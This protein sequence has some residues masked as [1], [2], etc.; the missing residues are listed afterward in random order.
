[1][2]RGARERQVCPRARRT[3]CRMTMLHKPWWQVLLINLAVSGRAL[4]AVRALYQL[5]QGVEVS[6]SVAR[7]QGYSKKYLHKRHAGV[8]FNAVLFA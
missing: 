5:V 8:C 3:S 2:R 7:C 6:T 1:M 4:A